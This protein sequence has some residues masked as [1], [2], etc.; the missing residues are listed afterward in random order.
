MS[1][2]ELNTIDKTSVVLGKISAIR[3]GG[4]QLPPYDHYIDL[5]L[6]SGVFPF[7]YDTKESCEKDYNLLIDKLRGEG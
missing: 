6:E 4:D 5:I 2:L 1:V 7:Y 3:Y